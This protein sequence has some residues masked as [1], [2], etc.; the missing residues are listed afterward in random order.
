M[1]K[2]GLVVIGASWASN[3]VI[4]AAMAMRHAGLKVVLMKLLQQFEATG[5]CG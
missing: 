3:V 5:Q 4:E 1:E 2:L